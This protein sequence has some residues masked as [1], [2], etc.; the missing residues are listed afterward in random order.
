MSFATARVTLAVEAAL[1]DTVYGQLHT[2]APGT[3]GTANVA[4]AVDGRELL[5]FG[6]FVAGETSAS[7]TFTVTGTSAAL[8][9]L[10]L[11]TLSAAGVLIGTSAVLPAETF[12]G[13][14]ALEVTV[15]VTATSS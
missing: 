5:E 1:G 2:G 7:A 9:F 14:G 10:T 3:A 12:A 4:P 15:V 13:A 8:S 11:W 6:A